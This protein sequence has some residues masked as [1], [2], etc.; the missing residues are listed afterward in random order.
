MDIETKRKEVTALIDN[1]K[2]HSDRLSESNT[3]PMLELSAILS[4]M[5]R[6]KEST[7]ILKYLVAK[8]QHYED[9]EFGPDRLSIPNLKNGNQTEEASTEIEEE[10][11][12]VED[13]S[14][15]LD[16]NEEIMVEMEV[17]EEDILPLDENI[18]EVE[19][20]VD[21]E[22]FEDLTQ[23]EPIEEVVPVAVQ[24]QEEDVEI[25][26]IIEKL[27]E[28]E[29]DQKPDLNEQYSELDDNSVSEQLQRQ[30][31]ADLVSSI[32]LNERYLYSNELFNGEME[33]FKFELEQ[34]NQFNSL[35][36]AQAYFKTQLLEQRNWSQDN[37]LV[38]ALSNLVERRYL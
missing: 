9:D 25:E 16:D 11:I 12:E 4:K 27:E 36:E 30:P 37:E 31:I 1:I 18:E 29:L 28:E 34:L 26:Q 38:K 23:E 32:G 17:E 10:A 15:A 19:Q 2:K 6:L 14:G 7:I 13:I 22:K 33:E 21:I 35:A 24:L 5:N 3:I 8:E 20:E